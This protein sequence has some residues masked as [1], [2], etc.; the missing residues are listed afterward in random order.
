MFPRPPMW[1]D[2]GK[3]ITDKKRIVWRDDVFIENGERCFQLWRT[4]G[5]SYERTLLRINNQRT[6][7]IF[8]R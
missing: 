2:Y 6:L 1:E 3:M 4:G 7:A 5:E 8:K